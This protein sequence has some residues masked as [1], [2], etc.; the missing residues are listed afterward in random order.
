MSEV[1]QISRA[2]GRIAHHRTLE[3]RALA[4]VREPRVAQVLGQAEA[5]LPVARVLGRSVALDYC[6]GTKGAT[7]TLGRAGVPAVALVV[8]AARSMVEMTEMETRR[9]ALDG[10]PVEVA[11]SRLDL[12]LEAQEDPLTEVAVVG[13]PMGRRP[14]AVVGHQL[15]A[16]DRHVGLEVEQ[17]RLH[18]LHQVV[19]RQQR[20]LDRVAGIQWW[21][22]S[23]EW[24]LC[25]RR[26]RLGCAVRRRRRMTSG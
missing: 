4:R 17:D 22:C 11:A 23:D 13:R 14:E 6:S 16:V 21:S 10:D 7:T 15:A 20:Q 12:G 1:F 3:V 8:P 9:W 24:L 19:A 18:P 25:K 2:R 26:L 5:Q